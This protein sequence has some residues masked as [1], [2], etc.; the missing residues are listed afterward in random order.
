MAD[1]EYDPNEPDPDDILKRLITGLPD[2]LKK[3]AE[4]RLLAAQQVPMVV[5]IP[6]EMGCPMIRVAMI[7]NGYIA[8]Y[9]DEKGKDVNR[10]FLTLAA[11]S[12]WAEVY[13][14]RFAKEVNESP[15]EAQ[16]GSGG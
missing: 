8:I 2:A 4:T 12:V 16:G 15:R 13:F 9:E 10:H 7:S 11:L 3:I 14:S 5:K 1:K 6:R